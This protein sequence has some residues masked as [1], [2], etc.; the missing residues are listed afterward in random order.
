MLAPL[1]GWGKGLVG[2]VSYLHILRGDRTRR[3]TDARYRAAGVGIA[4]DATVA[5][6]LGI[7]VN[8]VVQ[9]RQRRRIPLPLCQ[10][11]VRVIREPRPIFHCYYHE[12][13][14]VWYIRVGAEYHSTLKRFLALALCEKEGRHDSVYGL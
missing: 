7:T 3:A 1:A 14:R 8:A 10:A 6:R 12:R 2:G 13:H 5:R 9:Y 4:S 11:P